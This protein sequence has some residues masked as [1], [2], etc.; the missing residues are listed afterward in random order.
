MNRFRSLL[1]LVCLL[2]PISIHAADWM[3]PAAAHAPGAAGTNWRTDLRIV[4]PA[5]NAASVR[6][7]LLPQNAD[8][9]ARDRSVTVSVPAQG[10]LS[11]TDVLETQFAFTGNAALLVGS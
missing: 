3:V 6:I 5:A 8:N 2:V 4:N 10:Q 9:T 11:L 7:D 1:A